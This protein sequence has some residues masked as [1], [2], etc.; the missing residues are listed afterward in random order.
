LA[1]SPP[2]RVNSR[3]H[4]QRP[5]LHFN[6]LGHHF[7]R[8]HLH[9]S[10]LK[11]TLAGSPPERVNSRH[12]FQRPHLHFNTLGH[13]FQ[14]PHLH[15]SSLK[16]TLAG[17]PPERVN[18]RHHFQRAHLH[19]NTLKATSPSERV[20][21]RAALSK[22][23]PAIQPSAVTVPWLAVWE[24]TFAGCLKSDAVRSHSAMVSRADLFRKST[25]GEGHHFQR[26]HLHFSTLGPPFQ[27][28]YLH[29]NTTC[30]DRRPAPAYDGHFPALWLPI[31]TIDC[32]EFSSGH[33]HS[34]SAE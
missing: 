3:H 15:F 4:F 27:R 21:S 12:H 10:S 26:P 2:E 5:H 19:F 32:N 34:T 23:A 7:Q 16:V 14:R 29:I 33:H 13:H 24:S 28:S 25:F 6:T 9:F 8:P 20:N 22:T 11:V 18:S 30:H 31:Y 1:G 17:S